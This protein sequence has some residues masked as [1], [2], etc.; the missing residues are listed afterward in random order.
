MNFEWPQAAALSFVLL[1]VA[2]A[3]TALILAL[4][5]PGRVQGGGR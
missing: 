5:R 4:V 1:A 2:M 3:G